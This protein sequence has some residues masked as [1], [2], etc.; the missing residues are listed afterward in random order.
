MF[1]QA[2][3]VSI[4]HTNLLAF[5]SEV[6]VKLKDEIQEVVTEID[7]E[8]S[9][10]LTEPDLSKNV[11]IIALAPWENL[12]TDFETIKLVTEEI[13]EL[14][15]HKEHFLNAPPMDNQVYNFD[16]EK[17]IPIAKSALAK[18]P[19]LTRIR[20]ELVPKFIA[21]KNFWYNYFYR[22]HI[23]KE[24]NNVPLTFDPVYFDDDEVL[25]NQVIV[26]QD[27]YGEIV[28]NTSAESIIEETSVNESAENSNE[29]TEVNPDAE[30]IVFDDG[31]FDDLE[32]DDSFEL[33]LDGDDQELDLMDELQLQ[34]DIL[35][36]DEL[37][38]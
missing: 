9:S 36:D 30:N 27:D 20:Y 26:E 17:A 5:M 19:C 21:E 3:I 37:D 13:L 31:S 1:Y 2:S 28:S 18:D 24:A 23:I 38:I 16:F 10:V 7:Q 25:D 4:Y 6:G 29:K 14:S 12:D 8:I 15:K 32:F 33:N 34:I 35:D 22:I 11:E